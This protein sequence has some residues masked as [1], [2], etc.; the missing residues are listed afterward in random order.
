MHG[1]STVNAQYRMQHSTRCCPHKIQNAPEFYIKRKK[2]KKSVMQH[3][4]PHTRQIPEV[5]IIVKI[6]GSNIK[7][8]SQG[9][10]I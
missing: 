6:Y 8:L 4:C 10:C 7:V 3:K 1:D 2:E 5:T 9:I